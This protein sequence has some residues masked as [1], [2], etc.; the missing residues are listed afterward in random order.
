MRAWE[1][2]LLCCKYR[3]GACAR[4]GVWV[5][6]GRCRVAHKNHLP[7]GAWA[8]VTPQTVYCWGSLSLSLFLSLMKKELVTVA[9]RALERCVR[10]CP[11]LVLESSSLVLLLSSSWP[12]GACSC[13]A[14]VFWPWDFFMTC[15]PWLFTCDPG[16]RNGCFQLS[17][18]FC[19]RAVPRL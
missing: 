17:I 16:I 13:P 8:G 12:S 18:I 19:V 7:S 14:V 15:I 9:N 11:P 3:R 10:V 5:L 2:V 6:Q 1:L 4:L